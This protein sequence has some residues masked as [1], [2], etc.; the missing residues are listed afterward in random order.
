MKAYRSLQRGPNGNYGITFNPTKG[1]IEGSSFL[2]PCGGCI[3][4][5]I[6]RSRDWATRCYHESTM[7]DQNSFI[8]LTYADEHLP[9]DFG[10]HTRVWQL[11]M[12]RLRKAVGIKIRFFA[13]GEYTDPPFNRPHYHALIFGYQFPDIVRWT[14]RKGNSLYRSKLLE[15]IW[16][17][18]FCTVGNVTH[19]SSGYVARYVMKKMNGDGEQALANYT[20]VHPI[21]GTIHQVKREFCVMSRRP[22]IGHTW[23][24]K[25][26]TDAF[27]SDF[28]IVD[29]RKQSVPAYY[30]KQ[31]E[32][33]ELE[34][35]KRERKR[36]SLTRR[37]DNTPERL[38]VREE[39]KRL[40]LQQLKR[41]LT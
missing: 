36:K 38:K 20:R 28:V 11:F 8:T 2:L 14:Q 4:C 1:L 26:K 5:K 9:P 31:L 22:G 41:D 40:T 13:S 29:G 33:E 19:Q 7:H 16:P 30:S 27:P 10:L 3:G 34:H 17:Y 21:T 32:K 24:Q 39:V 18:G 37:E 25:Y 15:T 23:F 12:K 6:D 35:Y